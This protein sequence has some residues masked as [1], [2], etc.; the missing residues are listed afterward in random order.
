MTFIRKTPEE[1]E[2]KQNEMIKFESHYEKFLAEIIN[3]KRKTLLTKFPELKTLYEG[4]LYGIYIAILDNQ[5]LKEGQG[6]LFYLFENIPEAS[7]KYK[8]SYTI[9]DKNNC[10]FNVSQLKKLPKSYLSILK[11]NNF[12]L[13]KEKANISELITAHR[14]KLDETA[15]VHHSDNNKLNNKIKNLIPLEKEFF[16][17]L[18]I[19]KQNNLAKGQQYIPQKYKLSIKKK[20]KDAI[21]LEYRAC[22]LYYNHRI[23]VA[24]IAKTLRSKLNKASILRIVKLYPHFKKY[25]ENH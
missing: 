3:E 17:S 4:W 7:N 19:D 20:T 10:D 12:D 1:K 21:K 23:E 5:Q 6:K 15:Y 24:K 22:D 16:N 11:R 13:N 25:S 2:L 18:S 9:N 8:L 14:Y